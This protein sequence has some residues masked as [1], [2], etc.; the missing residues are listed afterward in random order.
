MTSKR[1][2]GL[3]RGLEALLGPKA[4]DISRFITENGETDL[5]R[6]PATLP[7]LQLVP[8]Q[9]Q[10]RIHMDEGALYELAESIKAQGIMQPILVRLLEDETAQIQRQSA[11]K[12]GRKLP[13]NTPLYE[14]IAGER[15][16]RAAHLAG[17]SDVPVLRATFPTKPPQPWRS[18]KHAARRP[19]RARRSARL[20]APHQR[21]WHDPRA[22]SAGNRPQAA[23]P[24]A[25]CY[26][27]CNWRSPCKPCSWLATST[28]GTPAPCSAWIKPCKS[29]LPTPSAARNSVREAETLVKLSA[30]ASPSAQKAKKKNLPTCAA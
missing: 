20:A 3:G 24:L 8:G 25:T 29:T 28:W 7:L 2:K 30:N 16:F 1:N 27:C 12:E 15:R 9:Y 22:S 17:L 23:A 13:A 14:I 11:A 26:A 5:A 19:Q 6:Q 18:L 4:P 21:I 10:P